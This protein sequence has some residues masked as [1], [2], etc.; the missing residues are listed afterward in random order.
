MVRLWVPFLLLDW[1]I[2]SNFNSKMVRLWVHLWFHLPK[3]LKYFNS[4]MVRLWVPILWDRILRILIS[5]P[6]WYDYEKTRPPFYIVL[7]SISIPKWYDYEEN[8]V[9][10]IS[11]EVKI[12]QFQNGTIMRKYSRNN[13]AGSCFISIPKWYDYEQSLISYLIFII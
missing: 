1:I 8:L 2:K 10:L 7:I 6:K 13:I 9:W 12:F 3:F 4:K 11:S 5:I